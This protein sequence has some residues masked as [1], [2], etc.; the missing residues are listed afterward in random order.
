MYRV[1]S[2]AKTFGRKYPEHLE[3]LNQNGISVDNA[4]D[5]VELTEAY[6]ASVIADYEG[7][8]LSYGYV[9]SA[10]LEKAKNLKIVAKHGVGV[11]EIDLDAAT[12]Y[13]V[14]VTNTP[15]CNDNAVAE[16]TIGL[17]FS[18]CRF[19]PLSDR[20][21]RKGE[22]PRYLGCELSKKTL[23]IIGLGTIGRG[24]A[25][26]AKGLNMELLGYDAFPDQEFAERWRLKLVPLTELLSKSDI[27]TIHV[28][29]SDK[30]RHLLNKEEFRLMRENAVLIN[31]ARGGIVNEDALYEALAGDRIAG[32]AMDVFDPEP[33]LPN[34]PLFTL[35]NFVATPHLGAYT[36]EA[37]YAMGDAVVKNLTAAKMGE[38]PPDLV[39]LEIKK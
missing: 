5:D 35:P 17:I 7:L 37:I 6:M 28:P 15:G 14:M 31:T 32:A 3:R 39:N 27:I 25:Q 4:P 30:T 2:T 24:V 34:N 12:R 1:F 26:K 36:D 20:L 18:T 38:W 8:I 29:Y 16:L 11:N 19:I 22:W 33:P 21:I 9:S 13:G 10:V 23:G